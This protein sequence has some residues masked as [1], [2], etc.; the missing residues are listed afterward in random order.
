MS[1]IYQY[2]FILKNRLEI[3]YFLIEQEKA[4]FPIQLKYDRYIAMQKN[5]GQKFD[6]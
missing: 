1:F 3:V 4:S 6:F 5:T 2:E